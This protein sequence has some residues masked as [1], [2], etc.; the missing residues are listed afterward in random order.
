[1]SRN[2]SRRAL[3]GGLAAAFV[4]CRRHDENR[5]SPPVASAVP[6]PVG[7][8][9][10][11]VPPPAPVAGTIFAI[12]EVESDAE[13]VGAEK[14]AVVV[15]RWGAPG[16]RFPVLVALHGR[17]EAVRGLDVGAYGWLRDY[18]LGHTLT[19]LRNPPL[20]AADFKG[21]VE[22][23]RLAAINA[24]LAARPFRGLVVACPWVPDLLDA[25][26]RA[27]LDAAAPFGR[28]VCGPLLDR[29]VAETPALGDPR[30]TGIDGVSLGGRAALLVGLAAAP[31]F[32]AIGTLQAAIQG[33]E[34]E[35]LVALAKKAFAEDAELRL[36]L[37]TSDHDYFR[38][39]IGSLHRALAAAK[40]PHE[41]L[42]LP[43]PH[44]YPFNRGPGGIE[45][46]L[47]HDRVLRGE[48]P[49]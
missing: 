45:M 35:A 18:E 26:N 38:E 3:L 17:G 5:P 44:D 41:Y 21:F 46:L 12:R 31:R 14:A 28:W 36:R 49:M 6:T 10:R 20:I 47:W 11:F 34:V 30:A 48:P 25:K 29:V 16:E 22:P 1:M 13:G 32:H 19:R 23:S 40:L 9:P 7:S 24:S 4:G 43:G 2:L 27:N 37:V 33:S 42:S 8:A 39:A 15:P